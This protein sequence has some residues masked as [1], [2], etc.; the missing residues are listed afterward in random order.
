MHLY[1]NMHTI[2][3]LHQFT[4]VHAYWT[5]IKK[6][7]LS[8]QSWEPLDQQQKLKDKTEAIS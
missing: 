8:S 4:D 7:D 6:P 2:D 3:K 1:K 5:I